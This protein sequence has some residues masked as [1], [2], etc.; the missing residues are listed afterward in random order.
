MAAGDAQEQTY[1][2]SENATCVRGSEGSFDERRERLDERYRHSQT[3]TKADLVQRNIVQ[4]VN[5]VRRAAYVLESLL[6]KRPSLS[7]LISIKRLPADYLE[8][9][10][11]ADLESSVAPLAGKIARVSLQKLIAPPSS[12][13]PASGTSAS[14]ALGSM[15]GMMEKT[16]AT[17][18]AQV[19][20]AMLA[21]MVV[22]MARAAAVPPFQT[23]AGCISGPVAPASP[24]T[25]GARVARE[26]CGA[27]AALPVAAPAVVSPRSVQSATS[28]T[29]ATLATTSAPALMVASPDLEKAAG[30]STRAAKPSLRDMIRRPPGTL[31]AAK[32]PP[33]VTLIDEFCDRMSVSKPPVQAGT[34]TATGAS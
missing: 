28:A 33:F 8:R 20:P 11:P 2:H 19:D 3:V 18:Q 17:V 27:A 22:Q 31:T 30:P 13:A 5:V 34:S 4:G 12:M 6:A 21:A 26:L 29:S 32:P 16:P 14:I 23:N 24:A 25:A 7:K 9:L 15:P 1:I 10:F